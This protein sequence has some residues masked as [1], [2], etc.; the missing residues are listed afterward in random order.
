M[1]QNK[2]VSQILQS[3]YKSYMEEYDKGLVIVPLP[4]AVGKTYNCCQSIADYVLQHGSEGK[5][6]VFI[7]SLTK[8][9]PEEDLRKAFDQR[10]LDYD[11]HVLLFK[12]YADGLISAYKNGDFFRV[13]KDFKEEGYMEVCKIL[14]QLTDENAVL[15]NARKNNKALV[16]YVE[17]NI[18]NLQAALSMQEVVFRKGIARYLS[19]K[20]KTSKTTIEDLVYDNPRYLWVQRLYPSVLYK[21]RQVY[22]MTMK[23]FLMSGERIIGRDNYFSSEWLQDKIVFIDEYDATKEDCIQYLVDEEDKR[24]ATSVLKLFLSIK[25]GLENDELFSRLPQTAADEVQGRKTSR[26]A[27][28]KQSKNI[29]DKYNLNYS[30]KFA[31]HNT[32]SPLF[33]YYSNSWTTI[34]AP[35][36]PT[37]PVVLF[38]EQEQRNTIKTVKKLRPEQFSDITL[39]QLLSDIEAFI[40]HF[41]RFLT[42]W[43]Q[44]YCEIMNN[45]IERKNNEKDDN[46]KEQPISYVQGV[47][48]LLYK[49]HLTDDEKNVLLGCYNIY[50]TRNWSKYVR[51]TSFFR[52]G[53]TWYS[54]QDSDSRRDD[55]LISMVKINDTPENMILSMAKSALIFGMSAT[56]NCQ[57]VIGNYCE[58]FLRRE[59]NYTEDGEEHKNFHDMLEENQELARA[60]KQN[61]SI[62][63]SNYSNLSSDTTDGFPNQEEYNPNRILLSGPAVLQQMYDTDLLTSGVLNQLLRLEYN[64]NDA[65]DYSNAVEELI[66]NEVE[67]YIACSDSDDCRE[68]LLSK[69]Y[70]IVMVMYDF[71]HSSRYQSCLLVNMNMPVV[72]GKLNSYII[73]CIINHTNWFF[74]KVDSL[75]IPIELFVIR[76]ADFQ[77]NRLEFDQK[78]A[79]G[80]RLFI[81]STY[82]TVGAGINLQ[83]PICDWVRPHLALLPSNDGRDISKKDIDV[84]AMFDI[85]HSVTNFRDRPFTHSMQM[86]N[87]IETE[88]C[89]EVDK[90]TLTQRNEQIKNG[91]RAMTNAVAKP[92]NCIS[93]TDQVSKQITH[94]IVQTDGRT[95]RSPWR[96]QWQSF[97]IYD[98]ILNALDTDYLKKME[99]YISPELRTCLSQVK[100]PYT[101]KAVESEAMIDARRITLSTRRQIARMIGSIHLYGSKP[102]ILWTRHDMDSWNHWR[103][104]VLKAPTASAK[105]FHG[106]R[107]YEDFYITTASGRNICD[108]SYYNL[109]DFKEIQMGFNGLEELKRQL[110]SNKD[111]EFDPSC[112]HSV[113]EAD[114][115]LEQILK[116]PGMRAFFEKQGYATAFVPSPYIINPMMYSNIYKGALGEVAGRFVLE[117]MGVRLSEITDPTKF[118]AFD[119]TVADDSD[120]YIDFKHYR[121]PHIDDIERNEYN[122]SQEDKIRLK[123]QIVG[124]K[125]VFIISILAP[126]EENISAH[127]NGNIVYI[128]YLINKDGSPAQ[129]N[130]NFLLSKLHE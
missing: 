80:K 24:H 27:L 83:H 106:D 96:A 95:K 93:I 128:P 98:N 63:Y 111:M 88:S 90:I 12:G 77:E 65:D 68:Y 45:E 86:R 129:D 71:A 119:Y 57:T 53:A 23:K 101:P 41:A 48:T 85:T 64:L 15:Q 19:A 55:T 97:Y 29:I 4:T 74:S 7:T 99:P 103:E 73:E 22:L 89:A 104:L 46:D 58:D 9:L 36:K 21:K 39:F 25:T 66:R 2:S 118:E 60:I 112:L 67:R 116:Y 82:Q 47:E 44:A 34:V 109:G 56:A 113:S 59:L 78:L 51:P 30:Y 117:S 13:P 37:Y 38:D 130:I 87:I 115:R 3:S 72:N 16:P 122:E 110:K 114:A 50:R 42:Q 61:L 54:F 62:K 28:L 94:W 20:A 105:V 1:S 49:F 107:F 18:K 76:S 125:K 126:D 11:E 124:A 127:T 92:Y 79:A 69:Y 26:A 32:Q 40:R 43:A 5:K 33:M 108:Y 123:M 75:Y 17:K 8:N 35:G 10:E 91:F 31:D 52:D 81:I 100:K 84:L 70:N 102:G 120:V 14:K 6:I 121:M